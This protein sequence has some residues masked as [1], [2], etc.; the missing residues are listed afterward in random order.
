MWDARPGWIFAS[1]ARKR[2]AEQQRHDEC[3]STHDGHLCLKP[4]STDAGGSTAN[5]RSGLMRRAAPASRE[6]G[7]HIVTLLPKAPRSA[8]ADRG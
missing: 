6:D 1:L 3:C 7:F 2:R 4:G 5:G 8:A